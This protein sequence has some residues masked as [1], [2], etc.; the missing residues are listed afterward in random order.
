MKEYKVP[1]VVGILGLMI[2]WYMTGELE[3]TAGLDN[4]A[5]WN[6]RNVTL[7]SKREID[8]ISSDPTVMLSELEAVKRDVVFLR[9]QLA[10][11]RGTQ[12]SIQH[13]IVESLSTQTQDKDEARVSDSMPH[14]EAGL[15]PNGETTPQEQAA[16]QAN[17]LDQHLQFE[18][19]D[20]GWSRRVGAKNR[21]KIKPREY[22]G[23]HHREDELLVRGK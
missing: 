4:D 11:I 10:E 9:D 20:L 17:L 8:P 22:P 3:T 1:V 18:A 21:V 2:I 5:S 12:L 6:K 7:S 15:L 13:D 14:N 19:P 23:A 16:A